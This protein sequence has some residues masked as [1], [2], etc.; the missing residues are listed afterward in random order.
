MPRKKKNLGVSPSRKSIDLETIASTTAGLAPSSV[1]H[2]MLQTP[3]AVNKKELISSL[4]EMFSHLDPAVVYMV[5]SECD[6]QVEDSMDCLLELSSDAKGITSA[7]EVSGFDSISASLVCENLPCS[8][9]NETKGQSSTAVKVI[10]SSEQ[11]EKSLSSEELS[12]LLSTSLEKHDLNIEMKESKN[13]HPSG[14]LCQVLNCSSS[15][16]VKEPSKWEK[17]SLHYHAMLSSKPMGTDDEKIETTFT[18]LNPDANET[19][20]PVFRRVNVETKDASLHEADIFAQSPEIFSLPEVVLDSG[21]IPESVILPNV[22]VCP[23]NLPQTQNVF[24]DLTTI[25]DVSSQQCQG[26]ARFGSSSFD[27]YSS[28]DIKNSEALVVCNNPRKDTIPDL[29]TGSVFRPACLTTVDHSLQTWNSQCPTLQEHTL[30]PFFNPA[31]YPQSMSHSFVTPV[32]VSPGKWRPASDYRSLGK[33][34]SP[35]ASSQLWDNKSSAPKIWENKDGSQIM[36]FSQVHLLPNGHMVRRKNTFV[37]HVLVLLRGVPGSGKSYLAR[38]LLED[39]PGGIIL[40]TDDYFYQKNGKYQFDADCLAEA[41]EWNRKRA[42]EAFEKGITPI[43]IDNT[44]TQAWEMKPYV[45][46]S[47]QHKYKVIFREPDTWWK[48]KPKELERRNSH[49]VS[50]EKIKKMLER[51]ERCL[52][53][54]SVLNSSIPDDPKSTTCDDVLHQKEGEGEEYTLLYERTEE[55]SVSP[56]KSAELNVDNNNL[57]EKETLEN[58]NFQKEKREIRHESEECNSESRIP[59]ENLDV[60]TSPSHDAKNSVVKSEVANTEVATLKENEQFSFNVSE[61]ICQHHDLKTEIEEDRYDGIQ[62]QLTDLKNTD[63]GDSNY[64]QATRPEKFS[65]VGDWPVDQTM[66]QRVKRARRLEKLTKSEKEDKHTN[67]STLDSI[68]VAGKSEKLDQILKEPAFSENKQEENLEL[69]A[70]ISGV[71]TEEDTSRLLVVG[72]WP[73]HNSLEQRPHWSKR[74]PRRNL[75]D[76]ESIQCNNNS[77]GLNTWSVLPEVSVGIGKDEIFQAHSSSGSEAL[78]EKKPIQN[79]RTR[80]HHKL[81]LTFTNHLAISKPEEQSSLDHG[82]EEKPEECTPTETSKYSQTEPQDFAHLWRLERNLI[83]SD[84]TRILH[85]RLDGFIPKC[86]DTTVDCPEKIPYKVTY[87]KSTYVEERELVSIDETENLNILCKLFE[88]FSFD[89]LKDLYERCNR[90]MDWT[91]GILLDSDEKLCKEENIEWLQKSE[92]Q[93]PDTAAS[94]QEN[95]GYGEKLFD[96]SEAVVSEINPDSETV[97]ISIDDGSDKTSDATSYVN[98][99]IANLLVSSL[100]NKNSSQP[101]EETDLEESVD[102]KPPLDPMKTHTEEMHSATLSEN[103]QQNEASHFEMGGCGPV[104]VPDDYNGAT[105]ALKPIIH[106][107]TDSRS[108]KNCQDGSTTEDEAVQELLPGLNL[109]EDLQS[110]GGTL[111]QC[112]K[113]DCKPLFPKTAENAE[114]KASNEKYCIMNVQNPTTSSKPVNIDCLELALPPELAIQLSEIFGP[115]G[116]DSESLTTEDYVVHIDLNLAREIHEKW[117]ASIMKRQKR[118]EELHSLFEEDPM[119]F[120]QLQ[121]DGLDTNLSQ[122]RNSQVQRSEQLSVCGLPQ[123]SA[124][125]EIFPFMDHWNVQTQKVSLRKIMSEEKA[126]QERQDE[127]YLLFMNRKDC[128]VRLKEKQ[129]LKIFPTINPNFL[130]DIFRDNNYSLEQTVQFL[131]IVLEADP[132]KTVVAKET[133]QGAALSSYGIPKKKVKKVKEPEDNLTEK[134]FQDFEYPGYDDFRAEAFLHHQHRQECLRKAGEAYHKGMKPVA[135]F[136]VQ[137][138]RFHEQKMKEAN[139]DAAVQIFEKVNAS[140]LPEN[141]VDLHGLHVDE[142]LDHLGRVLQEK[143]EECSQAGGKPY[144]YVITGR[145]N[146]SQGRVARIKPAVMRYLTSHKFRYTEIKPGCLKVMLK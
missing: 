139:R 13:C 60:Y 34:C 12:F 72:D 3:D 65:F 56:L 111:D 145:G 113:M 73:V 117:K 128:A 78:T 24:L 69:P 38:A 30:E 112:E 135:A 53:V 22:E 114:N 71:R 23:S 88:S 15:I 14:N 67:M 18:E 39:N 134:V 100:V 16:S 141:L 45:A 59:S 47:Q 143:T 102:Q 116:V 37:G 95:T 98:S 83:V 101:L 125:S 122:H 33:V 46:L 57:L 104:M 92:S 136:Y 17:A 127:K 133:T 52:T 110:K 118:G 62:K 48:F 120:E 40:S 75:S 146:H 137:Q 94:S 4:S 126:L 74:M 27:Q 91:T 5:L 70:C 66:G 129:L 87:E 90:D 42:K 119:F 132:V 61:T 97:N 89:A 2:I 138:G 140:K 124:A 80:K 41:H 68:N 29:C 32:A 121:L 54:N 96:S 108:S 6:F 107:V 20:E 77:S 93:I 28:Q 123:N 49:G 35:Q 84:D 99:E 76:S 86:I 81:A 11:S 10:N 105:L 1:E 109:L 130:M 26:S 64:D 8:V 63:G 82:L 106:I 79:K 51:Y 50:K 103:V 58:Q 142:A 144:L 25:N 131:T 7:S 115:V 31:F 55:A 36:N 19:S 9:T 85:G 44:N 21:A 43:I